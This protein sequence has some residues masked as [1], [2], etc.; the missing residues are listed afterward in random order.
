M[1]VV[2]TVL[3]PVLAL[4]AALVSLTAQVGRAVMRIRPKTFAL[5][6]VIHFSEHA[7]VKRGHAKVVAGGR[8]PGLRVLLMNVLRPAMAVAVVVLLLV[9]ALHLGG[10]D[11]G[12]AL[13]IT[14]AALSSKKVELEKLYKELKKTQDEYTGKAMPQNVGEE[15]DRK[16][17]EALALQTAIETEEKRAAR[18]DRLGSFLD[19]VSDDVLPP[20]HSNGGDR[21]AKGESDVVGYMTVGQ[22]FVNSPEY[23]RLRELNFPEQMITPVQFEN[24]PLLSGRGVKRAGLLP[25]TQKMIESKAVPTLTDVIRP[26]QDPEIVSVYTAEE[27]E[28]TIRSLVN[29]SQTDSNSVEYMVKDTRLTAAAPTAESAQKPEGTMAY[30]RATAPV[31]TIAEWIPVTE[32]QLAD[33]PQLQNLIDV[34]LRYDVRRVEEL[35]MVWGPG[36]GEHLLGIMNTPGVAAGRTVGGDTNLDKIRRSMSDVR[37]VGKSAPDG[38]GIHPYDWEDIQ[39]LKG[40][41]NRYVWVV[42]TDDNGSRIWGL[43]VVETEAMTNE[44]DTVNTTQQRVILVG[45]FRRGATLWDRM[46]PQVAVGWINDQFIRNQ[47]TIRGEERVAF[48]VKRPRAFRYIETVAAAA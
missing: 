29:V 25:I 2:R 7:W 20:T 23:K 10:V 40:T 16:S 26:S 18:V 48:G 35:E 9:A 21:R 1:R 22:A 33:V 38:V 47:R 4:V 41:D 3:W 30:S 34:D 42:V 36:T 24:V 5:P 12:Y 8:E 32:Q 28:L 45:A 17:E 27:R 19:T 14:P 31:R 6:R 44:L 15:F 39:L 46:Q 43:R 11:P 37:V 13:A